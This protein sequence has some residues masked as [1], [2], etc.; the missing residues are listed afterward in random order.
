ML[1]FVLQF[2]ADHSASELIRWFFAAAAGIWA[3]FKFFVKLFKPRALATDADPVIQP[4]VDEMEALIKELRVNR[5]SGAGANFVGGPPEQPMRFNRPLGEVLASAKAVP[6]TRAPSKGRAF[7]LAALAAAGVA[8][9][10]GIAASSSVGPDL[11]FL[12][13]A[14]RNAADAGA[15]FQA[16]IS[17]PAR[18]LDDRTEG[19]EGANCERD[20]NAAS[21]RN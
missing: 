10:W 6:A 2:G 8:C 13:G 19:A 17:Q 9:A 20:R 21:T 12:R 15:N 11:S 14:S 3:A 5:T 4:L 7:K 18:W 16:M 1:D